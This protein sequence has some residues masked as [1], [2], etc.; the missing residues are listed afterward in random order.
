MD[1]LLG[2]PEAAEPLG[3]YGRDAVKEELRRAIASGE[4]EPKA[5]LNAARESLFRRFAPTLVRAVNATGVLLHTNLGRAPLGAPA[6]D[7]IARAAAGYSTL[8]Y[9]PEGGRRGKRQ[10]HVR[11]AASALF[12]SEDALA[13]NN[14]ASAV[15]LALCA[16]ARGRSVLVSR[17]E[18]VAIGGS[19]R[20]P[21]ILEASG[22]TLREVGTT[23]RTTAEDFRRA[24]HP[25]A[26][27]I[28]TVH[29][30]NYEI[31]G[32]AASP[33]P[34]E[35]AAVAREGGIP[36]V[37]DQGTGC[38]VPLEEF[39]VPGETTV[40]ECLAAGADLVTFSGDKLFS[41][42]QAGIVVGRAALVRRLAEHPVARVVRPDK[43][44]LAALAATLASWKTGR[45]REFPV[46]RAAAADSDALERRG[47][48]IRAAVTGASGRPVS[49]EI[50]A[51]FA[52]F[53]GGTSPEKRFDSRA[54]AVAVEDLS[55]DDLAAKLRSGTPPVVARVE[56]GKVLLDLRSVLP[57]ED[58]IVERAL[59]EAAGSL[60][61]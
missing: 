47:E 33:T 42:P 11:H 53:G 52:V 31:R 54:L 34:A 23:N 55:A 46:Y 37:H 26:A 24:L 28:L 40:A 5:L 60:V 9:E 36:W 6:R 22:A 16:L 30:S 17:G 29:P 1:S 12:G 18:L 51:T 44:T 3:L 25:E 61:E 21:D 14:N 8:E 7:A 10:D 39:G 43:L 38:V 2:R 58:G 27:L 35:I 50:V 41:G 19:F 49:I 4:L 57:E 20:I 15:F 56:E 48:E 32:F 45:W 59:K 13:V